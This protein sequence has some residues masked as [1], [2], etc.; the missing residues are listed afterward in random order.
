MS[1]ATRQEIEY[2]GSIDNEG[3]RNPALVDQMWHQLEALRC[4][5]Q[6]FSAGDWQ[7]HH[8]HRASA[9]RVSKRDAGSTI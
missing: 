2:V 8:Q 3:S 9:W 7:P 4:Y 1:S 6:N 5:D